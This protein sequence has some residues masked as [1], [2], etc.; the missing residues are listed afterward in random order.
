VP[1]TTLRRPRP[2]AGPRTDLAA[3]ADLVAEHDPLELVVGLPLTLAG[4]SGP[5]VAS[6]R[7][8]VEELVGVL[9]QRRTPVPV[10]LVDERLSTAAA[11]KGLRSAGTDS[12]RGRAV[13]DQSAAVIIV[14]DALDAER[15]TGTPPGELVAR[16]STH[17]R[18]DDPRTT[19]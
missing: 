12:R 14:Q 13:I 16:P 10:R 1:V 9:A 2:G 17:R 3:L 4:G 6:V 5:A 7:A 8:Y 19:R 15:R 11:A 18:P